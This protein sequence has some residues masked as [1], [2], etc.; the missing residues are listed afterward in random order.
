M[1]P[2]CPRRT[3][4]T[5]TASSVSGSTITSPVPTSPARMTSSTDGDD[6]GR[7][8][9]CHLNAERD[10]YGR[11]T[12]GKPQPNFLHPRQG[13]A[14]GELIQE[15]F[16]A[17]SLGRRGLDEA[18]EASVDFLDRGLEAVEVGGLDDVSVGVQLIAALDVVGMPGGGQDHDRDDHQVGVSLD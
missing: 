10:I 2:P 11:M 1:N 12:T 5:R 6:T 3:I 15:A 7:Y 4:F 14:E 17:R 18:E 16:R 8:F 9:R 13:H